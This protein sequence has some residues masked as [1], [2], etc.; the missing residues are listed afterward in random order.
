MPRTITTGATAM[1]TD[2]DT[3]IT[4]TDMPTV[5]VMVTPTDMDTDTDMATKKRLKQASENFL[6][7]ITK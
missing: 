3:D 4:G 2:M 5:M 7:P 1:V 6:V